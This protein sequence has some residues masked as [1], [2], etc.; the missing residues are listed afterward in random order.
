VEGALLVHL[1]T[2]LAAHRWVVELREPDHRGSAPHP[3]ADPV[4][5]DLPGEAHVRLVAPYGPTGA[6]V[7]RRADRRPF[8]LWVAEVDAPV[9]VEEWLRW[10]GR[11][12]RYGATDT[13]WPIEAYQTLFAVPTPTPIGLGSAEMPSA[14]RPI[15]AEVLAR[16]LA[17]GVVVAPIT[18]H[19]GVSSLEAHE[20]PYPERY[21]VPATTAR[22]VDEAHAA[23]GRVITVGTTATRAIET[24]ADEHG[25]AH[26][27]DG[28]TDLVITPERGLRVVDGIISG[29][30]EPEAS[31]LLLMEAVAGR[32]LLER[33]YDEAIAHRYRWHEF[34]DL[35][36]VVP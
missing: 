4:V 18:L 28:W 9:P 30:H 11:P 33:S 13:A 2:Q 29:W 1:S 20:P 12:I 15:T 14:A 16:C 5:L 7:R 32:D 36:L 8:R 3:V 21:Q 27:G 19:C 17:A 24:D 22:L 6:V 26:A 35:H 34:G 10:V 23:G 25:H 31:H